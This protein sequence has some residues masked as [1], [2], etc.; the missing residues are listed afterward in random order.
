MVTLRIP[1][2]MLALTAGAMAQDAWAPVNQ[3][4]IYVR[5]PDRFILVSAGSK[6]DFGWYGDDP[7]GAP[8]QA[9]LLLMPLQDEWPGEAKQSPQKRMAKEALLALQNGPGWALFSPG[10]I[11]LSEGPGLPQPEKVKALMESAGWKPMRESLKAYLRQHPEDGQAWLELAYEVAH[12]A[13]FARLARGVENP[14]P[15]VQVAAFRDELLA[16]LQKL[17]ELPYSAETW[18]EPRP[19]IFS[20]MILFLNMLGPEP[21]LQNSVQKLKAAIPRLI[22]QDPESLS[23]WQ[24]LSWAYGPE[25]PDFPIRAQQDLRTSLQGVPGRP[26]PPV[27]LADTFTGFWWDRPEQGFQIATKAIATNQSLYEAGRLSRAQR[28]Q[29]LGAWGGAQV[30]SLLFEKRVDEAESLLAGLRSQAGKGWPEVAAGLT[31][32]LDDLLRVDENSEEKR[33]LSAQ[34][35]KMLRKV[36]QEPSP[37]EPPAPPRR[38]LRLVQV[39]PGPSLVD[40]AKLQSH[41]ALAPWDALELSWQPLNKADVAQLQERQNWPKGP[42]WVLLQNNAVLASGPGLPTAATLE[43]ALRTQGMPL[44]ESL[45]AF[46]KANPE[47]LDARRA[48]LECIRPRLPNTHL[49][50]RF[51]EDLLASGAP[52]EALPFEPKGELWVKAAR[53]ICQETA[54]QLRH[55]PFGAA[56]WMR[57]AGWSA[58]DPRTASPGSL[59]RSL[60][61]WPRQRGYSLPGP[62]P[63]ATS[64]AVARMLRDAQR[65]EELD[66]WSQAIWERG[67]RGWLAA[68]LQARAN[69]EDKD[70]SWIPRPVG[71][72]LSL[73]GEALRKRGKTARLETLK[74]EFESLQVGLSSLLSGPAE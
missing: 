5:T 33:L 23:L 65:N 31:L 40:W 3:A 22:T 16:P 69:R 10:G 26:W 57:Y 68:N 37:P 12:H 7:L 51:R 53:K 54:E 4:L 21:D 58:L 25:D 27:H 72:L 44:L 24:T 17:V 28:V 60:D 38:A 61:T 52:L 45:D 63:I 49:E 67:L 41:E 18:R 15:K 46:I 56:A 9:E 8:N 30:G 32:H 20:T 48:R 35:E 42:R 14:L 11:R 36:L 19:Q 6:L 1:A 2:L 29:A 66:S 13:S 34:Q 47:R 73:W 50:A 43:A 64:E 70:R 71:Q 62:I 55:W 59:L 39:D 74:S